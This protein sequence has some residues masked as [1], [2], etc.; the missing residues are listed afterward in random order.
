MLTMPLDVAVPS[1]EARLT[2]PPV[3]T[4]LRPAWALDGAARTLVPLPTANQHGATAAAGGRAGAE[5]DGT[6]VAGRSSCRS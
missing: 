2:L 4:V 6:G 1:P 5:R 3:L